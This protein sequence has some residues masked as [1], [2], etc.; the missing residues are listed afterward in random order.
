MSN[1]EIINCA[2]TFCG[3]FLFANGV[4]GIVQN[5]S[6]AVPQTFISVAAL[7][8]M[9][10]KKF[11]PRHKR[12]KNRL[13][14]LFSSKTI[15]TK[16]Q[17][18]FWDSKSKT[19]GY[20]RNKRIWWTKVEI[21]QDSFNRYIPVNMR[22]LWS[23][24]FSSA[25]RENLVSGCSIKTGVLRALSQTVL[26]N[27]PD[28]FQNESIRSYVEKDRMIDVFALKMIHE[29]YER[30]ENCKS[31]EA[32]ID[33]L[34]NSFNE[35][36]SLFYNMGLNFEGKTN[37]FLNRSV[38]EE[39]RQKEFK[40]L[41]T[42]SCASIFGTGVSTMF[43]SPLEYPVI[44]SGLTVG[45]SLVYM[46]SQMKQKSHLETQ[47]ARFETNSFQLSEICLKK[48]PLAQKDGY[49]IWYQSL[50]N[51]TKMEQAKITYQTSLNVNDIL[52]SFPQD[53]PCKKAGELL[54]LQGVFKNKDCFQAYRKIESGLT[55]EMA[56]SEFGLKTVYKLLLFNH[57]SNKIK[58]YEN[59]QLRSFLFDFQ[60][61]LVEF[62][63]AKILAN[64]KIPKRVYQEVKKLDKL[65]QEGEIS[66]VERK[67]FMVQILEMEEKGVFM[68]V[69]VGV[70][71]PR[72][73]QR[74]LKT[75]RV[76]N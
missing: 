5:R 50:K 25:V 42:I 62:K 66:S 4:S 56:V 16:G 14:E 15:L 51:L 22:N 68:H 11:Q 72:S 24:V 64:R 70:K 71:L 76:K 37:S 35:K 36:N 43:F 74:V 63:D 57:F 9:G 45:S 18:L 73:V 69:P 3:F 12:L 6:Y 52:K 33:F 39:G 27:I 7:S 2:A 26:E 38:Y 58:E 1:K 53:M 44:Y 32:V 49:I 28:F 60:S 10:Y 34:E 8:Y 75:E 20:G 61:S 40:I 54:F 59:K 13:D 31:D 17:L 21:E 29:A 41:E 30:V 46:F 65:Y 67:E 48:A 19:K 23:G 47:F 55:L